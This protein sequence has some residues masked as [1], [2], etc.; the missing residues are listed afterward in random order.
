MPNQIKALVIKVKSSTEPQGVAFAWDKLPQLEV[1]TRNILIP[2]IAVDQQGNSAVNIGSIVSGMPT[3]FARAALF[4]NALNN[5]QDKNAE[6]AGLML[7]YKSL[8]SEWKGFISC[9]AL[10]YKDISI[11]R[12]PLAYTDGLPIGETGNIY[13]P[14]GAFGNALFGR[15]PLW[16][17]QALAEN[18]EKVPFIDIISYKGQVLGGTSPDC[19]LFTSVAYRLDD[20]LPFVSLQNGRLTDPLTSD[21]RPDELYKLYGYAKHILNNMEGF[22]RQFDGLE[23]SIRPD[24]S[25]VSAALNAWM[26]DMVSYQQSKN[27]ARLEQ[28]TPPEVGALFQQPFAKLFNYS[29]ILYGSEGV[30]STDATSD[31]S[32][33]F[34]PKDLLLPD[35]TEI[36][37]FD[38][39]K[40]GVMTRN[41]LND[42]PI[43]LL[44]AET[45]GQASHFAYFS[46]PLTPLA[47]NVFGA[48]LDALAGLNETANVTSRI[49]AVYDPGQQGGEKLIVQLKLITDTGNEIIKQVVYNVI[50]ETIMNRDVLMWPNFISKQWGRYFLYSEI[51]HNDARFQAT[52]FIGNVNDD[53]FRIA[54]DAAGNPLYLAAKGRTADLPKEQGVAA[55]LHIASN[56]AVADNKYKY[57][58]YESNQ[59]FKG[60]RFAHAGVPCGFGVIRYTGM[61]G[62]KTL[63]V[64]ML[65]AFRNLSPAF[66]GVDFGSTNTSV[67]YWSDAQNKVCDQVRLSNKRVSLLGNDNKNNDE[68]PAVEDEI[69]FFQNDEI[70]TNAIKSVLTLH[71]TRRVVNE[72][73]LQQDSLLSQAVKGGFPCFEKN[74]PIDSATD[75]RYILNYNRVGSAELVYNMKWST[76]SLDK[77]YKTAYLGSLLLHIYAQLFVE[78]HEPHTLKW[79]YPSS[80]GKAMLNEYRAIWDSLVAVNPLNSTV[81]LK[82]YRPSDLSS[83]G[84]TAGESTWAAAGSTPSW[85]N[86]QG[87]SAWS[88]APPASPASPGWGA[89]SA[90]EAT[91]VE[92]PSDKG[93]VR[94]DFEELNDNESLSEACAV[95]NYMLRPGGYAVSQGEMLLCFDIGGSTTD[96]TV[97]SDLGTGKA[98]IKQNSIRFAAERLAQATKCSPNFKRVLLKVCEQK[99]IF[100][101]GLNKGEDKFSAAT[102]PYY[103]EQV[104]DR[105]EAA[106]FESFY[107][108]IAAECKEMMSVNLYITGLIMFY[109]GQ[110][111]GKLREEVVRSQDATELVKRTQPR[112]RIAFA[113]KG[114]RIFD[115]FSAV[116]EKA[117]DDYYTQMFLRGIGGEAVARTTIVPFSLSP[118]KI[119]DINSQ[120][121]KDNADIKYEVSKGL[122]IPTN[123]TKILV[124]KNKQAIEILGEDNFC[125]VKPGGQVEYLES[126]NSVIPEMLEHLGTHFLYRVKPGK[127]P[128]PRF[129]DFADLFYRVSSAMFGLKM[130]PA[131]FMEGFLDMNIENYIRSIP[132]FTEAQS[133]NNNEQKKFDYVA[134]VIILE[135]MKFFESHLLKGI[136]TS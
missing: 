127:P 68:R 51:P 124:P 24:Y 114:A 22:R 27:F 91:P 101:Q 61:T 119:I 72:N 105:L 86:A 20:R 74:L 136:Q 99:K 88:A 17:D 117:A 52:P 21:L 16:C 98:M 96:I 129:M 128:C 125:I 123:R 133:R 41:Y 36:V 30:I 135:G 115:W 126:T 10:N 45:R 100:I 110:L 63:P 80:M 132:E 97:L 38:F 93:P 109:S 66:L 104:V 81:K 23:A 131:D 13:E 8:I 28:Q 108:L 15:R 50:R 82:T 121:G 42:K 39:G 122:A 43:L 2:E 14:K 37:Q 87:S 4:D 60:L 44:S 25:A 57:E 111:V 130:T 103:F 71:D 56:N 40:Q 69:F 67:A 11:Q 79:S 95:A 31:S 19:L 84:D 62:S 48:N 120:R 18:A 134:P 118:L 34:D 92:I 76:Q 46:L 53:F 35:S 106:D 1:F 59:P 102:A 70:L 64:N 33:A 26:M 73:G 75:S 29:T 58:I 55:K 94:F 85:G 49:T 78:G 3:V 6:A 83:L 7:F 116:D 54:L 89:T 32:I 77:S 113:G 65:S 5:V 47:L 112:V 12:V 107:R 9:L 90:P